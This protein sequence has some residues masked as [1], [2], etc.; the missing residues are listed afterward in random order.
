MKLSLLAFLL[1]LPSIAGAVTVDQTVT[2]DPISGPLVGTQFTLDYTFPLTVGP[3]GYYKQ[4]GAADFLRAELSF[5]GMTYTAYDAQLITT[6]GNVAPPV[7]TTAAVRGLEPYLFFGSVGPYDL[8]QHNAGR[9]YFF[10]SVGPDFE[11]VCGVN[12]VCS[13]SIAFRDVTPVPVPG[14]LAAGLVGLM[15]LALVARRRRTAPAG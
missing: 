7:P 9:L 13:D 15:A 12:A 8:V 6:G 11:Y 1:T 14:G 5:D 3:Y 4:L 10:P 2:F